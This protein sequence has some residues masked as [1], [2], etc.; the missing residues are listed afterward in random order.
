MD[1]QSDSI[2]VIRAKTAF[3]SP[4]LMEDFPAGGGGGSV[5]TYSSETLDNSS[6][7]GSEATTTGVDRANVSYK[8]GEIEE[9]FP[10]GLEVI[11]VEVVATI[12][13]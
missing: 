6:M 11:T 5:Y 3:K 8:I 13:K 10:V 7:L 12:V 4:G 2:F 1:A 9:I